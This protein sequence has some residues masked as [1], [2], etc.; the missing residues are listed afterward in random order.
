MFNLASIVL[1]IFNFRDN[2]GSVVA[3]WGK[4]KDQEENMTGRR[5]H[6]LKIS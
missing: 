5:G 2:T 4:W 3:I 6:D 1:I